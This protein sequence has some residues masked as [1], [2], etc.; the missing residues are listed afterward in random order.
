MRGDGAL[1]QFE[2]V[3]DFL[4]QDIEQ[5]RF[6]ALLEE[7]SLRDEVVEQREHD[8]DHAAEV[9]DKEP[10]DKCFRQ[11]GRLERGLEQRT[12]VRSRTKPTI[13]NKVCRKSSTRSEM[14]GQ[15]AA[16]MITALEFLKP[17]RLIVTSQGS[18]RVMRSWMKR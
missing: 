18:A 4:R 6:G 14:T 8:R 1:V 16:Q 12:H 9:K 13:H 5:Q 11:R 7:V 17:P 2:R 3:R 15:S 10:G